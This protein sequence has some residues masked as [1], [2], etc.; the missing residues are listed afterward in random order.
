M[1][2]TAMIR[3]PYKCRQMVGSMPYLLVI[4]CSQTKDSSPHSMEALERYQGV[5]FNVIKKFKRERK[6]PD[7]VDIVIISAKYG[8]LKADTVIDDY[9]MQMTEKRAQKLHSDIIQKFRGLFSQKKYD[10]I[11][12]NMGKNY[13][14]AIKGIETMVECPVVYAKGRIGEKMAA[15]KQWLIKIS[16]SSDKQKK[17]GDLLG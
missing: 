1:L 14:P 3:N 17:L 7:D 4:G 2:I 15:M 10:E 12:V 16:L 13:L 6:L 8:L 9:D 11:F 5:N